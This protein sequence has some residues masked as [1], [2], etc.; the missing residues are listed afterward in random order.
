MTK[1]SGRPRFALY[2]IG[3]V[4]VVA[5]ACGSDKVDTRATATPVASSASPQVSFTS[6]TDGAT[7]TSPVALTMTSTD[8]VVEPAGEVHAGAGHLHVMV[9][10]DCVAAGTVIP[11]DDAHV[12]LG[13]AELSKEL[14]LAPGPHKLCLQA[15]DGA[16]AALDLTD[17]IEITV[18]G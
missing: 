7:V 17:E 3:V 5:A 2:S 18:S 16:H 15:A 13:K 4:M 6:P 12:H 14:V 1:S 8:F 11:K 10:V 9:D